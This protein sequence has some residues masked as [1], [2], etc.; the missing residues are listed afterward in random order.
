MSDETIKKVLT[1]IK[2]LE[3][4]RTQ[5]LE[6]FWELEEAKNKIK[7]LKLE[8]KSLKN[9]NKTLNI[10]LKDIYNELN[11]P[12]KNEE[13]LFFHHKTAK[14]EI[15]EIANKVEEQVEEE[16]SE[17]IPNIVDKD[18]VEIKSELRNLIAK[19]LKNHGRKYTCKI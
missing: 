6:S 4:E 14:E 12:S 16:I 11:V 15:E 1:Y 2:Q 5:L 3:A 10:L 13:K 19:R 8:N 17:E 7:N 9:E 18:T